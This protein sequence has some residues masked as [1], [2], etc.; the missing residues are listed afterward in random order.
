[1]YVFSQSVILVLHFGLQLV[2]SYSIA[3]WNVNGIRSLIKHDV[4][5]DIL[6]N[7][8]GTNEVDVFCLQ[9]TKIQDSHIPEL[10]AYLKDKYAIPHIF[11]SCSKAK[12]GYSGTAVMV[13][14]NDIQVCDDNVKYGIGEPQGDLEGRSV[15]I[16]LDSCIIVNVYV[17]NAGM[18]L[19]RLDYR[20]NTWDTQL[21][22]YITQLRQKNPHKPVILI[23]DLNVCHTAIDWYNPHISKHFPGLTV[24]EQTS[25]SDLFL[26]QCDMVDTYR[27]M[28]P[29]RRKYSYFSPMIGA[30]ARELN[31][32]YRL[33]YALVSN[34][35]SSRTA[36]GSQNTGDGLSGVVAN[37]DN[38][39]LHNVHNFAGS[40]SSA[41]VRSFSTPNNFG[42]HTHND[43][44]TYSSA[45]I[46]TDRNGGTF[47]RYTSSINRDSNDIHSSNSQVH[48]AKP[49]LSVTGVG[50][51]A[52]AGGGTHSSFHMDQSTFSFEP[53][54]EDQVTFFLLSTAQYG[55]G[56]S[57]LFV[58]YRHNSCRIRTV[59]IVRLVCAWNSSEEMGLF[60][61]TYSLI[62]FHCVELCIIVHM[63]HAK[64]FLELLFVCS[65]AK[66]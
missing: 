27:N 13:L 10:N 26:T 62:V 46:V 44:S 61:S 4:F 32:G 8:L 1:M 7:F 43:H 22:A 48:Q 36:G 5:G 30:K 25:F 60:M 34:P 52:A 20:V 21:A 33:D 3:S 54:I 37:S 66:Y 47:R 28:N 59:I 16:E 35:Y 29:N 65:T 50:S 38:E 58:C 17:P 24:E 41:A 40:S 39:D 15:T 55:N 42:M 63:H 19:K 31:L 6:G 51:M 49:S 57:L 12:K 45:G 53:F 18:D 64:Q 9:E 56:F 11:W 23:G 14:N 2:G